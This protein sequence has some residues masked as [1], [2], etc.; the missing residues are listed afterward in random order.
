MLMIIINIYYYNVEYKK[1]LHYKLK[2][3]PWY[4]LKFKIQMIKKD[5]LC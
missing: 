4:K 5:H 1:E 3:E 2:S